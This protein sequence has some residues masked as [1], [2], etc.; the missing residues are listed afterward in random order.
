MFKGIKTQSTKL[1]TTF[2]SDKVEARKQKVLYNRDIVTINSSA[3][4]GFGWGLDQHRQT[5]VLNIYLY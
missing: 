2:L 3:Y 5:F 1:L 4:P